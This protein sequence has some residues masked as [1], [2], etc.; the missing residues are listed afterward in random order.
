[1]RITNIS[2]ATYSVG[3]FMVEV[4]NTYIQINMNEEERSQVVSLVTDFFKA[5]QKEIAREI[6]T[7]QLPMIELKPEGQ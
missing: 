7:A 1:M 6:G 2:V 4:N 3:S 5:R